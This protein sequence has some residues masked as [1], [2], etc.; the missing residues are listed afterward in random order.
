MSICGSAAW[1]RPATTARQ[2]ND[3]SAA[4]VVGVVRDPE[5]VRTIHAAV[6]ETAPPQPALRAF[7]RALRDAAN[8]G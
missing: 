4:V 5:P 2:R 7:L 3:G 1:A 6:R 8:E